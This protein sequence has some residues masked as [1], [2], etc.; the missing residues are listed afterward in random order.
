MMCAILP[1]DSGSAA[2]CEVQHGLE[3]TLWSG[4]WTLSQ[5]LKLQSTS[6]LSAGHCSTSAGML[7]PVE[8]PGSTGTAVEL[9]LPVLG[10]ATHLALHPAS[11]QEH[12]D[13]WHTVRHRL[14]GVQQ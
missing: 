12:M 5:G 13:D 10:G 6:G 9:S 3:L 11:R 7:G 1:M 14:A 2:G 8:V 4:H